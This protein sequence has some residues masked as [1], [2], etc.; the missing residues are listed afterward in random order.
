MDAE[1]FRLWSYL[2]AHPLAGLTATLI[3]Y[4]AALELW[5]RLG[6]PTLANP[7]LLAIVFLAA[8]LWLT[9]T[10]YAD[11]FDGAQFIHVMLGPATVALALPL[12]AVADRIRAAMRPIVLTLLFGSVFAGGSAVA[13]AWALGADGA[14]LATI[15]P[16]SVTTPVAMAIAERLG[17]APSMAA[18]IVIL[19]GVVGASVGVAALDLARIRDQRARGFALGLGG[20]GIAAARALQQSETAGAFASVGMALNALATAALAPLIAW[21]LI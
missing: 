19:T 6:R 13:M 5:S 21:L 8:V 3:A 9:D 11:Y 4:V 18:A 17:G 7:V 20:H 10:P 2:S 1:A 12:Y 15:A 16:K 14:L